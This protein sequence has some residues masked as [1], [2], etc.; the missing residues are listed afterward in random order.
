SSVS[1][2]THPASRGAAVSS[3]SIPRRPDR[4]T[5]STTVW[6]RP[7]RGRHF[8]TATDCNGRLLRFRDCELP[9][10]GATLEE[11]HAKDL[12]LELGGMHFAAEDVGG[13]TKVAFKLYQGQRH[14]NPFVIRAHATDGAV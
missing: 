6:E 14:E 4:S 8:G 7:L 5:P 10:L 1:L 13:R 12:L 9:I 11:Q 2:S 3:P